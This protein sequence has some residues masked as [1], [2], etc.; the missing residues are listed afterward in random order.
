MTRSAVAVLI[1]A[2]LCAAPAS[3]QQATTGTPQ[4]LFTHE[5]ET[6]RATSR[7]VRDA[8]RAK[9]V[10]VDQDI[11]FA[12][13]TGDGRQDAI[14]RVDS[15]GAGGAIAV[16]VFSTE[17]GSKLHAVY[18]NQHVYRALVAVNGAALLL[19]T[20]RYQAG[21][22]VCCPKQLLERTLTW[23]ARGKRLVLRST[24]T[25]PAS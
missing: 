5:I 4:A 13:L 2:A 3:G 14:A 20:P 15:G 25:V 16:Y 18:R 23:S 1:V 21:D 24:R 10:F 6:D 9:R 12:D 22:D 17:G 8:L 7:D 11:T 19:S